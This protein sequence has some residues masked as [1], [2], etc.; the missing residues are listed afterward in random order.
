MTRDEFRSR[1]SFTDAFKAGAV[2]V[3]LDEAKTIPQV[4]AIST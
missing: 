2:R 3:V 4:L 1:W